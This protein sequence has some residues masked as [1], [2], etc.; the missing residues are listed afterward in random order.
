MKMAKRACMLEFKELAVKR[1]KDGPALAAV[2][3]ELGRVEQTL[4]NGVKA[5]AAG[6]LGGAPTAKW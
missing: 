2:A 1:G 6:K 3:K 4:R 5:A